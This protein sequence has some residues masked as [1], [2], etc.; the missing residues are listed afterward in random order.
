[1]T[2]V[3]FSLIPISAELGLVVLILLIFLLNLFKQAA[4][5]PVV[6]LMPDIIPGDYRSEAN[7]VINTMG[8]IAAIVGTVGLARLMDVTIPVPG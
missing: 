2:A 4:R 3:A 6:A 5:G 1:L 7:G 8:G